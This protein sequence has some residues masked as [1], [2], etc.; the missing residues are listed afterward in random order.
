LEAAVRFVD[1]EGLDAL[2][3]RNLGAELKT[4]AMSQHSDE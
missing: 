4:E 1:G 2:S 3:M